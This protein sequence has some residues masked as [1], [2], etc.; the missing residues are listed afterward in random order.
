MNENEYLAKMINEQFEA[1]RPLVLV[2]IMS[3]QGSTPRHGG[4]KMV[5]GDDGKTYG[6]I[7]GSLIEAAAI[8]EAKKVISTRKSRIMSYELSGQ[9]TTAPGMICGG[10]AEILLDFLP[11][12]A[13]NREFSRQWYGMI[14][15]G[16]D[17]YL[18]TQIKGAKSAFEV[19]GHAMLLPDSIISAGPLLTDSDLE[20]L[21]SELPNVS[22]NAI[23]P[24]GDTQVVVD[25][26][27]KLKTLY[28]FGAGHVAVPTAHLAALAG[29]RVV[30]IDDR[31][32]YANA[33]RFPEAHLTLVINDFN[34]A[35]DGL[36][37]DAD[38]YIVIVT[39][40]HQY[41]RAVL[42]Q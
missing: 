36:E 21:K 28:C 32:E 35:F 42:E 15:Q 38:A 29:F 19:L 9:D 34:H 13:E 18:L 5:V 4:T 41:D 3:L 2:S 8:R 12:S 16:K 10:K 22:H 20:K 11:A 33:E 27:R 40:G 24:L 14:R 37:I 39:R 23:L 31:P 1:G 25:R 26:I 7:G 17:F 6:T 30:V